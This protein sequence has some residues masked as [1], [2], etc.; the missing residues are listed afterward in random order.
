MLWRINKGGRRATTPA[1][2][3]RG[4]Q[5]L[6]CS[7]CLTDTV[8]DM[9]VSDTNH[10]LR[11]HTLTHSKMP[12]RTRPIEKFASTAAKCSVEVSGCR[13]VCDIFA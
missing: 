5:L 12:G 7:T 10:Q 9:F 2:R 8:N 13:S 3:R 6:A 11:L 1:E 4:S